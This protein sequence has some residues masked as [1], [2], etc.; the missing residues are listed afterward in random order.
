MAK[1]LEQRSVPASLP[2]YGRNIELYTFKKG[3]TSTRLA[4]ELGI[5]VGTL[6]RVRFSRGRYLD[7]ELMQ[8]LMRVFSCDPN[9][10]L[11][12]QPDIDYSITTS[13]N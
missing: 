2:V 1:V 4:S 5:S 6:R 9:D 11:L 12:P 7:L 3:W 8:E 10:L 13:F